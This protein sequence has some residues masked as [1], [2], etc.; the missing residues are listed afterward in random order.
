MRI[1][2]RLV[3]VF[4]VI[5]SCLALM[6]L[7][8]TWKLASLN[9]AVTIVTASSMP[10]VQYSLAM[11][12]E[13]IDMRNRET[14][15]LI[16]K[17]PEDLKETEG[18]L[19]KNLASLRKYEAAYRPLADLEQERANMDSYDKKLDIYLKSHAEFLKLVE[20]GNTDDAVQFFRKEGRSAFRDFLPTLDAIVKFNQEE[21]TTNAQRAADDYASGRNM[22]LIIGA[23]ALLFSAVMSAWLFRSITRPVGQLQQTIKEIQT[24]L[25]FT[26][27]VTVDGKDEIAETATSFNQLADHV[28]HT[29]QDVSL[30]CNRL[31]ELVRELAHSAEEVSSGSQHQTD[32]SSSMAAAIEELSTSIAQVSDSAAQTLSISSIAGGR[33]REGCNVIRSTLTEMQH[34]AEMI[35]QVAQSIQELGHR[36]VEINGIVQ[37]IREVADQT[38]LLALNASIEAARAGEQGRGFAVVADE[39]R[40]LAERTSTATGDIGSKIAAIRTSTEQAASGMDDAV[41]QMD[42]G[43]RLAQTAGDTIKEITGDADRVEQE[44]TTISSALREQN[45]AS[46]QIATSVEQIS[47]L[48]EHNSRVATMTSRLAIELEKIASTLTAQIARFR[49]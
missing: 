23:M 19:Q 32:A 36:S 12:A 41:N 11:R 15:L 2:Q 44:V 3:A 33:A 5:V 35:Q 28:Q 1:S 29:I 26:R 46:Q 42:R 27:R 38:N 14:Q 24:D 18:R 4:A 7:L 21:A 49:A 25:D 6:M 37:V 10:A 20:A 47:Q 43:V 16:A 30:A 13:A 48:T 31:A 45:V 17:N 40:K 39:V 22:L 8:G 34:I 9:K